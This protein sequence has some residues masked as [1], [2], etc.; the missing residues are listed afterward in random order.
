MRRELTNDERKAIVASLEKEEKHLATLKE[1]VWYIDITLENQEKIWEYEDKIHDY[2]RRM[3]KEK[4]VEARNKMLPEIQWSQN[5]ID[6]MKDQLS[7]GVEIIENK[8][9]ENE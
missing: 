7:N 3:D 1:G 6:V 2:K 5:S 4:F 8:G 9:G